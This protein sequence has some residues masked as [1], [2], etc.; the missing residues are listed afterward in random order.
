MQFILDEDK[1]V[2]FQDGSVLG[3]ITGNVVLS[4]DPVVWGTSF[5]SIK[6]SNENGCV[7]GVKI[8]TDLSANAIFP[9]E[10]IVPL[11]EV[12]GAS[13]PEDV[14]PKDPAHAPKEGKEPSADESV[15][16]DPESVVPDEKSSEKPAA[17]EENK[18]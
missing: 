6:L 13:T 12:P 4:K 7:M 8:P 2:S 15:A 10:R 14:T 18:N 3:Q 1:F 16:L 5:T 11:G 9:A 17:K